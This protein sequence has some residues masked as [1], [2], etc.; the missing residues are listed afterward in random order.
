MQS[1]IILATHNKGKLREFEQ[2]LAP[3][4][5]P[6]QLLSAFNVEPVEETGLTF[7]ENA[8]LKARAATRLTGFPALADDSGLVVDALGGE[9]GIHSARYAG[10]DKDANACISKLLQSL[11]GVPWAERTARFVCVLVYLEHVHD[12][13][14]RIAQATW[15]GYILEQPAGIQGFGYDPVF[16]T[17]EHQCSVAQLTLEQKQVISHRGKA[18]S[19]LLSQLR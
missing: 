19:L 2:S 14:P 16:Y 4:N 13:M 6:I 5:R 17:P 9:P 12:P 3:L 1:P 11:E 10:P 8:L 7:V 18:L 15:E